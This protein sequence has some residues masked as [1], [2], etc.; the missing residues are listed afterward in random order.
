MGFEWLNDLAYY[1]AAFVPR[2]EI[3]DTTQGAVKFKWGSQIVAL[4]PG[5]HW[6]WPMTTKFV[7]YPT[8][9]QS[10]DLRTITTITKDNKTILVGAMIVYEIR[11][12]ESILAHTW[13]PENT[14][15]DIAV[16]TIADVVRG[17]YTFE[18]LIHKSHAGELD[19]E[20]HERVAEAL[21]SYGVHVIMVKIPDFSPVRLYKLVGSAPKAGDN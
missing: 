14:V 16:A 19:I 13:D 9:R 7:T 20:I 10:T 18:E 11:H 15:H 5:W 3:V 1:L 4:G 21:E 12:I 6:Y 2:C 8:A 17:K